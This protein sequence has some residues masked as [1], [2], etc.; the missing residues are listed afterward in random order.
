MKPNDSICILLQSLMYQI[1]LVRSHNICISFLKFE[2]IGCTTSLH[3]LVESNWA[4][5]NSLLKPR[6]MM[7]VTQ[8]LIHVAISAIFITLCRINVD[9]RRIELSQSPHFL[10]SHIMLITL[11]GDCPQCRKH[12]CIHAI[13]SKETSQQENS[14][15]TYLTRYISSVKCE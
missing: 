10:P 8:D 3:Y 15:I 9:S 11:G 2:Q 6:Q 13:R 1:G 12:H 14:N 5:L 4:S 7:F